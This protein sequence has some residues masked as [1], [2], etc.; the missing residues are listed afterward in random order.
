MKNIFHFILLFLLVLLPIHVNAQQSTLDDG[1]R[2]SLARSFVAKLKAGLGRAD[3]QLHAHGIISEKNIL[4]DGEMLLLQPVLAKRFMVDGVIFGLVKNNKIL[5]SL[6]DV[7]EVL[8]IPISLDIERKS[9]QGWY[10]REEK[11]FNLDLNSKIMISDEGEFKVSDNVFI[12]DNDIWIPASELGQWLGF[13]FKPVTDVQE[14]RITSPVLLPIQERY[15]RR[16]AK[17]TKRGG[18]IAVTMPRSKTD[19]YKLIGVPSIDIATSSRYRRIG[20]ADKGVDTHNVDIRTTGDVGYGALTTRSRLNNT[21]QLTS[22][23]A[24]Y[25]QESDKPELLG[26][27]KARKFE[28]GDVI[29]ARVPFGGRVAQEMGVRVT[30]TDTVRAF[31]TPTT[32]ISGTGFAGWDVEL[33]R[34]GQVVG[35]REIGEDGFYSFDDVNLFLDDNNFKLIFYGPQG[36]IREETLFVPVANNAL[37]E[38]RSVYDVSITMDGESFYKKKISGYEDPDK[39]SL[40]ISAQYEKQVVDGT[41][42]SAG[43]WSS[44]N[45]GVRST[46]VNAGVSTTI[47][48]TLVNAGVAVDDEGEV[49]S[50]LSM[51]RDFGRH[52]FSNSLSWRGAGFDTQSGGDGDGNLGYLQNSLNITG[53]LPLIGVTNPRYSLGADYFL[54]DDGDYYVSSTVG[55]NVSIKRVSFNEQLKYGTGNS[56]DEDELS[57]FTSVSGNIG[58]NRLRLGADYSIMPDS[59]LRSVIATYRRDLTK[60][61]N[62]ELGVTKRPL[63]SLTE[64]SAKLDWQAG[65]ARISPSIRYN[66]EREFYAVLN[67][68]FGILKDPSR[69]KIRLYDRN[70]TNSGAV[71]AFV[72]LDKDGDGKFNGDDEPLEGIVVK[73][74]QNGGRLATD[75]NGVALFNRM[76][77]LRL[78]DILLDND[79]LQ[80]PV[81]V[82]SFDG[83][84]VLPRAGYVAEVSFPIH[85]SGELDGSI[86]AGNGRALRNIGLKLYNDK[87]DVEQSARTDPT[88]FYYFS[89]IPPGRYFLIIDEKSAAAGGFI[90]PKPQ[91]IEIGYDGTVIYSNN[92]YV[93]M[94]EGDIPSVFMSDLDD[95][96]LRHP[97]IDFSDKNNDLVLNLGEFNSR[98]LMSVVWYKIRSRYSEILAGGELFVPP[99]QSYANVKTGK[100]V[101]RVGLSDKSLESA[102]SRCRALMVRA[103]YCMV[104]IYPSYMKHASAVD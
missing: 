61:V 78:T 53:P 100:H 91:Q 88:G 27:L 92:L 79:S 60:K 64:Y 68:R 22:V 36:E 63:Q 71:S 46:A 96:K 31:N 89:Q 69:D 98:L 59:E 65:F 93:D 18:A 95:Y 29:T 9:A 81:W 102:Y 80:D 57:S 20:G 48:Q 77:K 104:E 23:R 35:F 101:L 34:N 49:S 73:A 45:E 25:S 94:G 10:V 13:E 21:N 37:A 55:F 62:M 47:A 3:N 14:L 42:I 97:H 74:P 33:Y 32:G 72:F 103:Q 26:A 1:N 84:S 85:M 52:E 44:Q 41:T 24:N 28:I 67:T 39:G 82:S 50:N 2:L 12:K 99:T 58:K 66:T 75:E 83:V 7:S 6:R 5:L 16:N 51:R 43:L 8:E 4:S 70:L 90:R 86:Y 87:G 54:K 19:D 17:Y 38:G 76:A 15:N 30:N 40:N 11:E 56:L